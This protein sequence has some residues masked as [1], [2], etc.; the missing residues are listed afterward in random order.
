MSGSKYSCD[1]CGF[2]T[3][4]AAS[5]R[6][7][8]TN[9]RHLQVVRQLNQEMLRRRQRAAWLQ[10]RAQARPA[11][12]VEEKNEERSARDGIR[13]DTMSHLNNKYHPFENATHAMLAMF[14]AQCG[15]S[16]AQFRSLLKI[17]THPELDLDWLRRNSSM[18]RFTGELEQISCRESR[19][20]RSDGSD[21]DDSEDLFALNLTDQI[22]ANL[23]VAEESAEKQM[24][25]MCKKV[26]RGERVDGITSSRRFWLV[27]IVG[28]VVR[29][30]PDIG[31]VGIG[32]WFRQH[33]GRRDRLHQLVS[34]VNDNGQL[35]LLLATCRPMPQNESRQTQIVVTRLLLVREHEFAFRFCHEDAPFNGRLVERKLNDGFEPLFPLRSLE[36]LRLLNRIN[37]P[38]CVD[39]MRRYL[40]ECRR[41]STRM[42]CGFVVVP[43]QVYCD[44]FVTAQTSSKSKIG[45]YARI[46]G[47]GQIFVSA[48]CPIVQEMKL[49]PRILEYFRQGEEH[50]DEAYFVRNQRI[51]TVG[52]ASVVCSLVGDNIV[53]NRICGTHHM[54]HH[55][56]P[57]CPVSRKFASL[58]TSL[59]ERWSANSRSLR[60]PFV[61]RTA[62]RKI[63]DSNTSTHSKSA[64]RKLVHLG[65]HLSA[66]RQA[67]R[68]RVLEPHRD[69]VVL[70]TLHDLKLGALR[71]FLMHINKSSFVRRVFDAFDDVR[72]NRALHKIKLLNGQELTDV[73]RLVPFVL[74]SAIDMNEP[75]RRATMDR[76]HRLLIAW[77]TTLGCLLNTLCH[78]KSVD[79]AVTQMINFTATAFVRWSFFLFP[80]LSNRLKFHKLLHAAAHVTYFGPLHEYSSSVFESTHQRSKSAIARTNNHNVSRDSIRVISRRECCRVLA[81]SPCFVQHGSGEEK[82]VH[83]PGRALRKLLRPLFETTERGQTTN[84]ALS[85]EIDELYVFEQ[86]GGAAFLAI[87]NSV[88]PARDTF[89]AQMCTAHCSLDNPF[90]ISISRDSQEMQFSMREIRATKLIT[91]CMENEVMMLHVFHARNLGI[92]IKR[93]ASIRDLS[94]DSLLTKARQLDAG[95]WRQFSRKFAIKH[96][97]RN[98]SFDDQLDTG[99]FDQIKTVLENL[100]VNLT[101]NHIRYNVCSFKTI[102]RGFD[103]LIDSQFPESDFVGASFPIMITVFGQEWDPGCYRDMIQ[104]KWTFSIKEYKIEQSAV[105][106]RSSAAPALDANHDIH[107]TCELAQ[108]HWDRAHELLNQIDRI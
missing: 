3:D 41:R 80:S 72:L 78:L 38:K 35:K 31:R 25:H 12:D 93:C 104:S 100:E 84:D 13:L 62:L 58:A 106:R 23:F 52:F 77:I 60:H 82:T 5:F 44:G 17:L 20:F 103:S 89:T 6:A 71:D 66:L 94:P 8:R 14:W 76:P 88:C 9:L 18:S 64:I 15:L 43:M 40:G 37:S 73:L 51:I 74:M 16:R 24:L 98:F 91:V 46:I 99:I 67:D 54:M 85:L 81:H 42:C 101:T 1:L 107:F 7:H 19:T 102:I 2:E 75:G 34:F 92:L 21:D 48:I 63:H 95:A 10:Q 65:E 39:E 68:F 83:V 70:E 96:V 69:C 33:L 47:R 32:M 53:T 49:L 105:N 97:V 29:S 86:R 57:L 87:V 4:I 55:F 28:I 45:V 22:R 27:P 56:C 90:C 61:V 108:F 50:V 59:N 79:N 36:W 30:M 11:R 26:M